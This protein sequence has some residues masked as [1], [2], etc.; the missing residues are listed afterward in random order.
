MYLLRFGSVDSGL[1]DAGVQHRA[2]GHREAERDARNGSE[3]EV[4]LC[5]DEGVDQA[6]HDG[7]KDD[8]GYGVN[9]GENVVWKA[10]EF[11]VAGYEMLV[12]TRG[13]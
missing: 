10:V 6:V 8:D 7:D 13:S 9:V 2:G 3:G 5:A 1:Q 11:H 12:N 4:Q